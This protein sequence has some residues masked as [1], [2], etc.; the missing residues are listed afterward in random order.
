[1]TYDAEF[2]AE[3][4]CSIYDPQAM[5]YVDAPTYGG[6]EMEAPMSIADVAGATPD[7]S[8]L[9][10]AI[11][12]AG[13]L[14]SFT[15]PSSALT[16]FAPTNE[17]FATLLAGLGEG[18]TLND[19]SPQTLGNILKYHVVPA[20]ATSDSLDESMEYPTLEGEELSV[21]LS[22][23]SV[24]IVGENSE[25]NVIAADVLAGNSVVHVIDAVLLP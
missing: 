20:P 9:V 12:R 11:V 15:D 13:L 2:C 21:V 23:D 10:E 8:I 14:D 7:L 16:V 4:G 19:I 17:A 25:A 6:E 18:V 1:M 24:T 5:G 22:E 3:A